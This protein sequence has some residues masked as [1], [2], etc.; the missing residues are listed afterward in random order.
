MAQ[1]PVIHAGTT[2][3][4]APWSAHAWTIGPSLWHRWA[5]PAPMAE[6]WSTT[7]EDPQRGAITLR[8]E[9]RRE[10]DPEACLVVVHG[11]GGAID[12][13]YCFTAANAAHR[14]G[15]SCLRLGL[16]GADRRGEDF[17]HAGLH[18]DIAA[19]VASPALA[20]YK[21]IYVLGYSLGGHVSLRY[22]L[23]ARDPRVRAVAAVCAP[24]DLDRSA[25]HIDSLRSF[26]YRR[27]VLDGLNEIY[28][29]V[30]ARGA[31]PTPI[32]QVAQARRIRDWDELTVVPRF[33]FGSVANYYASMSAGP[34]LHAL[35]VP[36][37]LVQSTFD[38]MVPPWTYELHLARKH[39][40]LEVRRISAGGHVSFPRV[41]LHGDGPPALLED[42]LLAWL[43]RA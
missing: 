8:G 41:S 18:A 19:A 33:G 5:S 38:P 14:A 6:A 26:I 34:E 21:R 25:T 13:P 43:V 42:Q 30:A 36:C 31:V 37:L 20:A 17:Y 28:N 10:A 23:D 12:R 27:H 16:R 40:L 35:R 1:R 22:A 15:M 9:L 32:A 3:F 39:P 2:D 11:L 4:R 24:L 7:L 29:A